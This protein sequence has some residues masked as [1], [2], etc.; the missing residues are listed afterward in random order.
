MDR[1][2]CR[3][4]HSMWMQALVW[5]VLRQN[6]Q[7]NWN[8]ELSYLVEIISDKKYDMEHV[9]LKS[10]KPKCVWQGGRDTVNFSIGK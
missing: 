4:K 5:F 7:P 1:H 3:G 2:K 10:L 9:K 6:M 8:R